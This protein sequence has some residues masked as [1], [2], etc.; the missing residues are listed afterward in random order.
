MIWET[1]E[2]FFNLIN[3]LIK[4]CYVQ[5]FILLN[6]YFIKFC[7]GSIKLRKLALLDEL[8]VLD[9]VKEARCLS[10]SELQQSGIVTR[11]NS[12]GE[13]EY[14]K[15][16]IGNLLEEKVSTAMVKRRE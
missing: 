3:I 12:V 14:D 16:A 7:F 2:C 9:Q 15:K 11:A 6:I 13:F 1:Y 5:I 4:I 10:S 8:E